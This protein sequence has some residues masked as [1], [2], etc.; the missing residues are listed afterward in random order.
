MVGS[1][2]AENADYLMR[3]NGL[4]NQQH[5]FRFNES[6]IGMVCRPLWWAPPPSWWK[7][8][9]LPLAPSI[10]KSLHFA[11]GQTGKPVGNADRDKRPE[12]PGSG[13]REPTSSFIE[14]SEEGWRMD[15]TAM[16][17]NVDL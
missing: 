5:G 16:R 15:G 13:L 14:Q 10:G 9:A 4:G 12:Y 7:E 1:G 17:I 6:K 11:L 2:E 8:Y 3:L